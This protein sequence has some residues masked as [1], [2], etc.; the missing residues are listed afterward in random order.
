MK[1]EYIIEMI[2]LYSENGV[3]QDVYEDLIVKS[4]TLEQ[5]TNVSS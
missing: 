1:V 2:W 3:K 5:E 4:Y